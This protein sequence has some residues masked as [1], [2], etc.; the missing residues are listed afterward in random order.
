MSSMADDCKNEINKLMEEWT[1]KHAETDY[2]PV[3]F[4]TKLSVR[5]EN[6]AAEFHKQDPDPFDDRHPAYTMPSCKFGK[7]LKA[8]AKQDD[9]MDELVDNY[10]KSRSGAS[11]QA[12]DMVL[13][14]EAAARCLLAIMPGLDAYSLFSN[15][16][17]ILSILY[18]W[19]ASKP[20]PLQTYAVGILAY[21]VENQAIIA[22]HHAD[23]TSLVPVLLRRLWNLIQPGKYAEETSSPSETV[24]P[25]SPQ[26][27]P[28][29]SAARN[30]PY[31][32]NESKES[33]RK[34]RKLSGDILKKQKL[35]RLEKPPTQLHIK[36]DNTDSSPVVAANI[37]ENCN[38]S[39][40]L[41]TP[42]I[43]FPLESECFENDVSNSS[44]VE[45]MPVVIGCSFSL[46]PPLSSGICERCILNFL[47][48]LGEYQDLLSIFLEYN[49]LDLVKHYL[50]KSSTN[51][52]LLTF[53]ALRF[54]ASLLCHNKI[55]TK[56]IEENGIE[57][58]LSVR[59]PSMGATGVSLCLYYL[60]YNLDAMERVCQL[61]NKILN[62]LVKY[63]TWLLECSHE[64]GRCHAALFFSTAFQFKVILRLFDQHNGLRY[65]LNIIST[66][67]IMRQE[68]YEASLEEED[69]FTCRQAARNTCQ[70]I[71]RYLET[72]LMLKVTLAKKLVPR[73]AWDI[74]DAT[75]SK[76]VAP[77]PETVIENLHF[78]L[79]LE[80]QNNTVTNSCLSNWQPIQNF[81]KLDGVKLLVQVISL[82]LNW[83][84][85]IGQTDTLKSALNCLA[86]VSLSPKAQAQL[87][88]Q[89]SLPEVGDNGVGLILRVTELDENYGSPP[90]PEVL[91]SA[92][93][94]IINCVCGSQ[95]KFDGAMGKVINGTPQTKVIAKSTDEGKKK[96]WKCVK[97]KNG[98]KILLQLLMMTQPASHADVNRML[99]CK[100][101][102]GLTRCETVKQI[103]S[104]LPTF[105]N[106]QIQ[107]LTRAPIMQDR[108]KHHARFCKFM[109]E[110]T[111]RVSGKPSSMHMDLDSM[112]KAHIVS[113]TVIRF[114]NRELLQMIH[115]HLN[116]SGLHH[117]ASTLA[118]E[119]SLHVPTT[120][121]T[122]VFLTP[123]TSG[124]TSLNGSGDATPVNRRISFSRGS[125][126]S[127]ITPTLQSY[128]SLL[129]TPTPKRCKVKVKGECSSGD[130]WGSSSLQRCR[131]STSGRVT[132][133]QP[134]MLDILQ[135]TD[136]RSSSPK[137][138]LS[139]I[140]ADYLK[141]QHSQ[142][143]NPVVTVPEFSLLKKHYC[144]E[145]RYRVEAPVNVS[146]RCMRRQI[147]PKCGG[148][149]G[150]ACDRQFI[151]SRFRPSV[152]FRSP[153]DDEV[154]Y[155][156]CAFS[157][158]DSNMIL[159]NYQGDLAIRSLHSEQDRVFEGCASAP[160]IKVE[161][162]ND[163][164]R[165]LFVAV[166]PWHS[167]CSI[168]CL[169]KLEISATFQGASYAEFSK[170]V[171]DRVIGT[172]NSAAMIYDARTGQKI[173][174][175]ERRD[176]ASLY[177][178]NRATFS[179]DDELVLSDGLLWD[180]R[181]SG[182]QPIHKFDKF[183]NKV[184]GVFHPQGV[185][186]II[187]TEIWDLRN[188]HLLNTVPSIDDCTIR[189]NNTGTV[190]FAAQTVN[191]HLEEEFELEDLTSNSKTFQTID[192][193]QYCP[194]SVTDT[195]QVI[196]DFAVDGKDSNIA[197][198]E[199]QTNEP[200][201][202]QP[203]V[204][205]CRLYE[206][207]RLRG[208][209]EDEE[210]DE[211]NMGGDEDEEDG[212]NEDDD[213][214]DN[215][216]DDDDGDSNSMSF[217]SFSGFSSSNMGFSDE[218]SDA[219]STLSDDEGRF[220]EDSDSSSEPDEYSV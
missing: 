24:Q 162:A 192:A 116:W 46:A 1:S 149:G 167:E 219:W 199:R 207:G 25:V 51:D 73:P 111:G 62:S 63:A 34:K 159:G 84:T 107:F 150:S 78:L 56:F 97:N 209:D 80:D 178:R 121:S 79:D 200:D 141:N 96:L 177:S 134:G 195:K 91:R 113:Q 38:S 132:V 52:G 28:H 13:L 29:T 122:G 33:N 140:V 64:S 157:P 54:F 129:C 100:A 47:K 176:L 161:P 37:E 23:N 18:Q 72:H 118:R 174:T 58:L 98:I 88:E 123:K 92:L 109:E 95:Y 153:D 114:D 87:C 180:V 185:E 27:E 213:D 188:Y 152:L 101:L 85:Y 165:I 83:T 50:K 215:D 217:S 99:A 7:L 136:K 60:A 173:Q 135:E 168:F 186:V 21:A 26:V 146:S 22:D 198:I 94:V 36:S 2:D 82:A 163:D 164:K 206:I 130:A 108:R 42:I 126:A 9:F 4:L 220:E 124:R 196:N 194:L 76:I 15:N 125:H 202:D 8:L 41:T 211:R 179:Y 144:P 158:D 57:R 210:E 182:D 49:A 119:A 106:G 191:H 55:T 86:V 70:T 68:E 69:L 205:V 48:P 181:M 170:K 175:L 19:A 147:A 32:Q 139:T 110:L 160:I 131:L 35:R 5:F 93:C 166:G 148:V 105:N 156:C 203:S 154:P 14:R 193:Q 81:L 137:P 214:D 102:C 208:E 12:G 43:S 151:Y 65:L 112:I 77:D 3:P 104:K 128:S 127:G 204:S 20:E 17:D 183:S 10:I 103:I 197:V 75:S 184:S 190:M 216:A 6:E 120:T 67:R 172:K 59:R 117:S 143:K 30:R 145:P 212:N 74:S 169:D 53:S 218:G 16:S 44:W 90:E 155:T 142:C 187:N 71:K 40:G 89:G 66:L 11:L 189:F 61:P 45:M 201:W 133:V 171:Q 31:V 138:T 115:N 39:S